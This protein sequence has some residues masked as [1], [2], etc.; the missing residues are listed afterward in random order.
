M[1]A[2]ITGMGLV[3]VS[4]SALLSGCSGGG[5]VTV[6]PPKS[7][8][9]PLS[10][11]PA[12]EVSRRM[13]AGQV[14]LQEGLKRLH[15]LAF[16]AP[17]FD[18]IDLSLLW[19]YEKESR[20]SPTFNPKG[21]PD[22]QSSVRA[23]AKATIGIRLGDPVANMASVLGIQPA[24]DTL[25]KLF[26]ILLNRE[27]KRAF[28]VPG[29]E[30]LIEHQD[31]F[32]LEALLS[33]QEEKYF[34]NRKAHEYFITRISNRRDELV[35]DYWRIVKERK[36]T[37]ADPCKTSFTLSPHDSQNFRLEAMQAALY[38]EWAIEPE[39]EEKAASLL[40]EYAR[41]FDIP[42][43]LTS[44][45]MRRDLSTKIIRN[46]HLFIHLSDYRLQED[47]TAESIIGFGDPE[48]L[49]E[50][51]NSPNAPGGPRKALNHLLQN[52]TL[53]GPLTPENPITMRLLKNSTI[54]AE[55]LIKIAREQGL[56]SF[57]KLSSKLIS[58]I[59]ATTALY[60]RSSGSYLWD[61]VSTCAPGSK[62]KRWGFATD[63]RFYRV[64]RPLRDFLQT[65]YLSDTA[66]DLKPVQATHPWVQIYI[67]KAL[68]KAVPDRPPVSTSEIQTLF[69][70]GLET[71]K[72]KLFALSLPAVGLTPTLTPEDQRIKDYSEALMRVEF[73]RH[74]L[75]TMGVSLGAVTEAEDAR[76]NIYKTIILPELE[77]ALRVRFLERLSAGRATDPAQACQD[78]VMP[79]PLYLPL[80]DLHRELE[81]NRT[82]G[83]LELKYQKGKA[84]LEL[85]PG[86]FTADLNIH[87]S[88]KSIAFHPLTLIKA[89]GKKITI[90]SKD[91]KI[92]DAWVDVSS[93]DAFQNKQ[94]DLNY[95][96]PIGVAPVGA[97]CV[98]RLTERA[99]NDDGLASVAIFKPGVAEMCFDLQNRG[100]AQEDCLQLIKDKEKLLNP[101]YHPEFH[102]GDYRADEWR[103]CYRLY[104]YGRAPVPPAQA[105]VGR[106]AGE[107]DMNS[108]APT[109]TGAP[110][111]VALGGYGVLGF[112]GGSSPLCK[113]MSDPAGAQ[114]LSYD[115]PKSQNPYLFSPTGNAD[116]D[117]YDHV[118]EKVWSQYPEREGKK[119]DLP[120]EEDSPFN[121]SAGNGGQGGDASPGGRIFRA[122]TGSPLAHSLLLAPGLP[123]AGGPP[124]R[125]GKVPPGGTPPVQ[126]SVGNR[127]THGNVF[128]ER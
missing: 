58:I 61:R 126:G 78:Q 1:R 98:C 109:E 97:T 118:R 77:R 68:Q 52:W 90:D 94:R 99:G 62:I 65:L 27:H 110:L 32:I 92:I 2:F 95:D 21:A 112:E 60:D 54:H 41:L 85:A 53:W 96:V 55:V 69:D 116:T 121:V 3:T 26:E 106:S 82:G 105:P 23:I 7:Q 107:I 13:N 10:A 124:G 114:V 14:S 44:S 43:N 73:S 74:F 91:A 125:C 115:S 9:A 28:Q 127:S 49:G 84:H 29:N 24:P 35:E 45:Q 20:N 6:Q 57:E 51:K 50:K 81:Q 93:P 25:N 66:H 36:P 103:H 39:L 108:S 64:L 17:S 8:E 80:C 75:D 70:A 101:E 123:G 5:R 48:R 72:T 40:S 31:A 83:T 111:L 46:T 122:Q 37:E 59:D 67:E 128:I 11:I 34:G 12:Y 120:W 42:E 22:D 33:T 38:K 76:V 87:L 119:S 100:G 86:I 113:L 63:D 71:F 117:K 19:D 16:H 89:P 15:D 102:S 18:P 4:I 47:E 104:E 56:D 88:V 30:D 79:D